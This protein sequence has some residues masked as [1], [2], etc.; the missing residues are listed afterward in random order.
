MLH[1]TRHFVMPARDLSYCRLRIDAKL[2]AFLPR[3][4][5]RLL[6]SLRAVANDNRIFALSAKAGSVILDL[7]GPREAVQRLLL[8]GAT[9]QLSAAIQRTVLSLQPLDQSHEPDVADCGDVIVPGFY[10]TAAPLL[11]ASPRGSRVNLSSIEGLNAPLSAF[12]FELGFTEPDG[13]ID[14]D[15]ASSHARASAIYFA[16]ALSVPASDWW[17]NLGPGEHSRVMPT[18]LRSRSIGH[19]MLSSD[20]TLKRLLASLIHPSGEIGKEFWARVLEQCAPDSNIEPHFRAWM[21]PK[22]GATT[23]HVSSGENHAQI[24]EAEID[25]CGEE[26]HHSG[27]PL[28]LTDPRSGGRQPS[29]NDERCWRILEE[30][31]L[32]EIRRELNEGCHFAELRQAQRAFV[33]AAYCRNR[34]RN[35]PRYATF[36]EEG[37]LANPVTLRTRLVDGRLAMIPFSPKQ[38]V[39]KSETGTAIDRIAARYKLEFDQGVFFVVRYETCP[40]SQERL[41]RSYFSGAARLENMGCGPTWERRQSKTQ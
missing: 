22:K 28:R 16:E 32:P 36:L 26:A 23:V 1:Q 33:M 25:I 37:V 20:L 11:S 35:D 31:V 9:G 27:R 6:Q 15:T 39:G 14:A 13:P 21:V 3:D 2:D 4:Q 5:E 10:S 38:P 24:A 40:H 7:A 17:V 34:W 18:T 30:T 8:A 29:E 41:V 19:V 12:E